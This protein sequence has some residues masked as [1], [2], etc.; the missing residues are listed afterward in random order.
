MNWLMVFRE[1]I[2]EN[3]TEAMHKPYGHCTY[4]LTLWFESV[5]C[6]F[7]TAKPLAV[8]ISGTCWFGLEQL[9][10]GF[11]T[12]PAISFPS[13]NALSSFRPICLLLIPSQENKT[14]RTWSKLPF[15]AGATWNRNTTMHLVSKYARSCPQQTTPL[16][17]VL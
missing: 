10:S 6:K 16:K 12:T 3:C 2:A 7:C 8:W 17:Y 4:S 1:I 11:I 15:T 9:G 5:R 13:P 14:R